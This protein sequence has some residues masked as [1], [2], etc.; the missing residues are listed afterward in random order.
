[1]EPAEKF[2][3]CNGILS[4][5]SNSL[6]LAFDLFILKNSEIRIVFGS[7]PLTN[8]NIWV[9][10]AYSSNKPTNEVFSLEG[11]TSEGHSVKSN[12]VFIK[13]YGTHSDQ[14]G[15]RVTMEATA[16]QIEIQVLGEA[17]QANNE[18]RADFLV[19]GFRCSSQIQLE[20]DLG[21]ILIVGSAKSED[22]SEIGGLV[23]IRKSICDN[24]RL[25]EW[26][27]EVKEQ[28]HR[29]LNLLSFANIVDPKVKTA[30][31]II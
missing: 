27:E 15:S 29:I 17:K 21:T 13:K 6:P 16:S 26:L 10:I 1:M 28:V 20:S 12:S 11:T 14:S 4:L 7:Q 9:G 2:E 24:D 18:A 3:N 31:S 30:K 23:S 19:A 22:F 5:D 25:T 8:D